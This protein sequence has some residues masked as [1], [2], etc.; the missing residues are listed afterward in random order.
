MRLGGLLI[1]FIFLL[2]PISYANEDF[3]DVRRSE[4]E[5]TNFPEFCTD[6][7]VNETAYQEFLSNNT[8]LNFVNENILEDYIRNFHFDDSKPY[9][10]RVYITTI[11][12]SGKSFS[13]GFV[14]GEDTSRPRLQGSWSNY[15]GEVTGGRHF[16]NMY[17]HTKIN[18]ITGPNSSFPTNL[19]IDHDL[20]FYHEIAHAMD[21]FEILGNYEQENEL[22]N[23]TTRFPNSGRLSGNTQNY[24]NSIFTPLNPDYLAMDS[25]YQIESNL[26]RIYALNTSY[27]P[28]DFRAETIARTTSICLENLQGSQVTFTTDRVICEGLAI[29]NDTRITEFYTTVVDSF[30][31][32]LFAEAYPDQVIKSRDLDNPL[33]QDFIEFKEEQVVTQGS[34]IVG[35]LATLTF[36]GV[37]SF[38]ILAIILVILYI[39]IR[40]AFLS[41]LKRPKEPK[42]I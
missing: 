31:R 41:F 17:G 2:I 24:I 19:F 27:T 20:T 21:H 23:L 42:N 36:F 38:V 11:N 40:D 30:G 14:Y 32:E 22:Y 37:I 35:A 10:R 5:Y 4:L 26:A 6:I 3:I 28:E 34:F 16:S 12:V 29:Y 9:E 7:K 18:G 39:R 1:L 8:V 13:L 15:F 33:C 25:P